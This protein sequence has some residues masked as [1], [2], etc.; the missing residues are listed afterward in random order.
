M[1]VFD[2][3][4]GPKLKKDLIFKSFYFQG[5]DQKEKEL[6]ALCIIAELSNYLSSDSKILNDLGATIKK[7]FFSELNKSPEQALI[8]SL[9]A[10][11]LFL[12][13]LSKQGNMRWLGN[14]NVAIFAI[15]DLSVHFSKAGNIRL[16]MLRGDEYHDI[17]ENLEF[18]QPSSDKNIHLFSNIASGQ[19]AENDKLITL[20]HDMFDFFYNELSEQILKFPTLSSKI[21]GQMLKTKK[22]KMEKISGIFFLIFIN[23]KH[24]KKIPFIKNKFHFIKIK[25]EFLLI[26]SL[27]LILLLSYLI[28]K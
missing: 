25:K 23:R 13:K 2:Y 16:L 3:H 4:I 20:T 17:G 15:K 1:Q 18:Q 12:E 28:F 24:Q 7:E 9:R 6:G 21:L 5:E 8:N 26:I 19:L 10:G 22:E 11:N 14:L 27:L